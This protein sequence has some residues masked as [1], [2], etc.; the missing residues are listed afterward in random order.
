MPEAD[1]DSEFADQLVAIQK[2]LYAYIL[3]LLPRPGEATD[4]LQ[5]TNVVLWRDAA[6]FQPGTDFRAWAYRVAYYQVLAQ[7]RKQGRDRLRFDES[8]LT[9]LAEQMD[10]ESPAVQEEDSLALRDC[11]DKLPPT[12]RDLICRRYDAGVSVKAMAADLNQPPNAVA[13][14]LFRIRQ[15]LLDCIR[16]HVS[17]RDSR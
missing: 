15:V 5:E 8:L 3:T 14:R 16:Q 13:V 4:V 9:L 10:G 12:D 2:G 1:R 17:N 11:L 6:R 7:R